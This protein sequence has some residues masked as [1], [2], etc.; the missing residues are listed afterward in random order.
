MDS[1]YQLALQ[2]FRF[3]CVL[4]ALI[5]ARKLFDNLKL[6]ER[7]ACVQHWEG[8]INP[9]SRAQYMTVSLYE[10]YTLPE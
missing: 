10:P 9:S 7:A 1:V 5:P 4:V 3:N 8:A 6:M 2:V